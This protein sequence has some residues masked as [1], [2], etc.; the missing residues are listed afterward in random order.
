VSFHRAP[1]SDAQMGMFDYFCPDPALHCPECGTELDEFQG[2]D[3]PCV[4]FVWRQSWDSPAAQRV[5]D[6]CAASAEVRR[7]ARLPQRFEFYAACSHCKG[8]VTFTGFCSAGVWS[9]SVLGSHLSSG[10]T[11]LAYW[12]ATNWRQCSACTEAWEQ[13]DGVIRAG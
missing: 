8:W 3:G 1:S 10:A 11:V 12:V 4:L 9:E 6:D 13:Y 7:T 5:D 2:K